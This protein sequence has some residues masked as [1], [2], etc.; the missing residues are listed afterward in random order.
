MPTRL[1][2]G[3]AFAVVLGRGERLSGITF[4]LPNSAGAFLAVTELRQLDRRQRDADE[5]LAFL[6]DHFAA[7]DVFAQVAFHLAADEFSEA[8]VIALDFLAH[9]SAN[10]KY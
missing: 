10:P 1:I 3:V 6:T 2:A 9:G 5:I 8:L 7:A 4:A